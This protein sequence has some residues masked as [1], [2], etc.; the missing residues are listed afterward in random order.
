MSLVFQFEE[1]AP[2]ELRPEVY[3]RLRAPA[4]RANILRLELLQRQGGVYVDTD[5]EALR[6]AG[7]IA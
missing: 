5:F 6:S 4:E 2:R 3:E 7:A 1:I